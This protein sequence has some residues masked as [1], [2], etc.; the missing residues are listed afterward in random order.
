LI[1]K[2]KKVCALCHSKSHRPNITAYLLEKVLTTLFIWQNIFTAKITGAKIK[3]PAKKEKESCK[4]KDSHDLFPS[5]K[6]D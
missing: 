6:S 2:L 1:A 4:N 3:A 5:S